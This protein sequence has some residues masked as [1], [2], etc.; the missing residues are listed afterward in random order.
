MRVS[1]R[2]Q[3]FGYPGLAMICFLAAAGGGFWLLFSILWQD[4][5]SKRESQSQRF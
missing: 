2:F 5:K 3:L 1:T 4:R